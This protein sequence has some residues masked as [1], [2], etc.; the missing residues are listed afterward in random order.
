M[1][2]FSGRFQYLDAGGARLQGGTCRLSFDETTLTLLPENGAP[3]AFDLGDI[4]EFTP[5]D[6]ELTLK[7][8]T[9]RSIVT[10]QYGKSFQVLSHDL[11]AAYRDRVVQCLLLGDL[12]EVLR[13]EGEIRL[14]SAERDLA[15][16]GEIRL[17]ESN[18]AALPA[19]AA[20]FQWRLA[21][22]DDFGFDNDSYSI[23]LTSGKERFSISKLAKKTAQLTGDLREAMTKIAADGAGVLH[24]L[25][26]FLTPDQFQQTA[27]VMK[28]GRAVAVTRLNAIHNRMEHALTENAVDA[29]LRPYF[30]YLGQR[31]SPAGIYAG[32]KFIRPEDEPEEQ[33][34]EVP[35]D[36]TGA[37]SSEAADA[38]EN[39]PETPV[40]AETQED[41]QDDSVLHWFFFPMRSQSGSPLNLVAWEAS[42]K[43]G[44]ATYFFRLVPQEKA[45]LLEDE[46]S[47]SAAVEDAV[48]TLNRAIVALNFRREP[49]YLPD[50]SLEIQPRY[51]RYAIACRN[52][53]FLRT[54]RASFLGRAIHT[55]PRAWARQVDGFIGAASR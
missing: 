32:F 26:P 52:L 9:G 6:Y 42:S 16:R 55:T 27:A 49:I 53:P 40:P 7:L 46:R 48:R 20:G 10:G 47:G 31:T 35:P 18:I 2:S 4:Q 30:D 51:R 12:E 36:Q 28:E 23:Q 25:F 21:D 44:R 11:L 39:Q 45:A 22:I 5:G 38:G 54:L 13:V 14:E 1:P 29:T 3:L 37:E 19:G 41:K 33:P 15:R 24:E 8:Y 17:Y 43:T 34:Q 50:N